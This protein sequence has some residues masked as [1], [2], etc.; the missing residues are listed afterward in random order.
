MNKIFIFL[1]GAWDLLIVGSIV[2]TLLAGCGGGGGGSVTSNTTGN[3]PSTG[4]IPPVT[5]G[6]DVWDYNYTPS[7]GLAGKMCVNFSAGNTAGQIGNSTLFINGY[8]EASDLSG[9]VDAAGK[10]AMASTTFAT[11]FSANVDAAATL[12]SGLFTGTSPIGAGNF[13]GKHVMGKYS[14][15]WE[16]FATGAALDIVITNKTSAPAIAMDGANP[17]VAFV[18]EVLGTPVNGSTPFED[19]VYVKRWNGTQW[20]QLGG[21][22]NN[23]GRND[24]AN[25][26]IVAV[27]NGNP[28]VTWTERNKTTLVYEAYA[29]RWDNITSTWVS[30]GGLLNNPVTQDT[31]AKGVVI[32]IN[33]NPVILLTYK[34]TIGT[35]IQFDSRAMQWSA[36]ASTWSQLGTNLL[37][38]WVYH[39]AKDPAGVPVLV[40]QFGLSV[41]AEKWNSVTGSWV[42]IGGSIPTSLGTVMSA[43][44]AYTGSGV[45][46]MVYETN[47]GFSSH[48]DANAMVNGIWAQLIPGV[49][50]DPVSNKQSPHIAIDP[51]DGLPVV[52][53]SSNSMGG[54]V[55]QKAY[56]NR[57]KP[58]GSNF[59]S[60]TLF[61]SQ[62]PVV[63][64]DSVGKLYAASSQQPTSSD[65]N[66]V[67]STWP[68]QK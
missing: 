59:D 32:D 36:I 31:Y 39:V 2:G 38:T 48:V 26:P 3:L 24:L 40:A 46:V 52:A 5:N 28:V 65:S 57:W 43:E 51:T 54:I 42:P 68:S 14:C 41:G 25:Q 60:Y 10:V 8:M 47:T 55:I 17:V 30:L 63:A 22:L 66:I 45:P 64:F 49:P 11:Q 53:A 6:F 44:I 7:A 9:T 15:F 67:L 56:A 62:S 33:N 4:A 19:K 58:M 61:S 12:M 35:L 21:A 23:V 13:S 29:K 34:T 27:A 50:F 20:V 37:N 1:K 16:P 18:E